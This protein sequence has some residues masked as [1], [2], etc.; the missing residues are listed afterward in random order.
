MVVNVKG[1]TATVRFSQRYQADQLN[2]SGQK[3]LKLVKRGNQ[4]LI[5]HEQVGNH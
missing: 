4:W 5:T 2:V 1:Q 3:T